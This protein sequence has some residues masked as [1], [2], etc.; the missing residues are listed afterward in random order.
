[1]LAHQCYDIVFHLDFSQVVPGTID[2]RYEVMCKKNGWPQSEGKYGVPWPTCST[3]PNNICEPVMDPP[4]NDY[5]DD[6]DRT[7]YVVE[8]TTISFKCKQEGWIA[9]TA[10]R[11]HYK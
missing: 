7:L 5:E 1:M 4:G 6:F 3:K 10:D 8:G 11:L 2:G 9:G